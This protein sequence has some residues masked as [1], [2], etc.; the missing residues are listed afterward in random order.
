LNL[1]PID[2]AVAAAVLGLAIMGGSFIRFLRKKQK[3][4]D[5]HAQE[6]LARQKGKRN[7]EQL[8]VKDSMHCAICDK[9]TSPDVDVFTSGSWWHRGCYQKA[10]K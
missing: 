10:V 3:A 4:E 9:E 6:E 1:L 7:L 2:L 5:P 8:T